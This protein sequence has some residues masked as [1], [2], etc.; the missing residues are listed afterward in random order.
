MLHRTAS[1]VTIALVLLAAPGL[2]AAQ[3]SP[4]ELTPHE[5]RCERQT[6][7]SVGDFDAGTTACLV[8][9]HEARATDPFRQCEGFFGFDVATQ[10]CIDDART[11]PEI[12]MIR[13]CAAES[14]PECYF[15][16]N[17]QNATNFFLQDA[18]FNSASR[19]GPLFCDD[20]GSADGL[21]AAEET[22]RARTADYA[23]RF[24]AQARKCFDAC[25]GRR[26]D[27]R[28]TEE[29]C[30][31]ESLEAGTA[32]ER[33]ANCMDRARVRFLRACLSC[34]APD[35]WPVPDANGACP[36]LLDFEEAIAGSRQEAHFCVDQPRCGDG[37]LSASE[38]CEF[39]VFPNG[40][41]TN[42][43]C[44]SQCECEAVPVCGDGI[45]SGFEFCDESATPNGCGPDEACVNCVACAPDVCNAPRVVPPNGGTFFGAT[46]GASST[47]GFCGGNGPEHVY[48]WTPA[49]SGLA[50]V[51]TCGSFFDTVLY[52]RE[53]TCD[54]FARQLA[55]N[56]DSCG[57][58]SRI[59][60]NVQAGTTYYIFVDGFSSSSGG[61]YQLHVECPAIYGSPQRAFLQS[62]EAC[63]LD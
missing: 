1:V 56:D 13:R 9:C 15:G 2:A 57:L 36:A 29:A 43:T 37:F 60:F 52:V 42:E 38:E 44:T 10:F 30:R 63:L 25:Q 51:N 8:E 7:R 6:A 54:P 18:V 26:R 59:E 40:C 50:R 62:S 21:T 5:W 55:C 46:S 20:S 4:D 39:T 31:P 24:Q 28:T 49:C 47:Q 35:C 14:C 41:G 27:G 53:L 12:R 61:S 16:G 22:C 19:L 23:T 34:D 3:D 48:R 45:I 58:Q 33:L 17:C 32:D 11:R